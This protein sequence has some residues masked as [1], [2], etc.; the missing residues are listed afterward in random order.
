MSAFARLHPQL[1][2]ALVHELGW[3]TLRPVQ[4]ET[5]HAVLDGCNTIVLAPTAGGK[6]EAG[7]FPVLSRVLA[8]DI[9]PVAVLYLCPLRA[10]LNNLEGRVKAYARM[11]GLEAFKWHGDVGLSERHR[12]LDRPAHILM[13]TPESIEVLL[14]NRPRDAASLLAN[15]SAV[16]VDEVHAF[17]GDDRGAH[18]V[19]LLERVSRLGGR[20]VQRIGLS[21]TVG[22][23]DAI[24]AWLAGSS[25]RPYRRVDPPRPPA[26]RELSVD[27]VD[28]EAIVGRVARQV[29]GRKG[30]V[31]V[32]SRRAAEQVA[33]ALEE[34]G[35]T[36]FVHHGSVS[37]AD[38]ERA[39]AAFQDT[40]P[41]AIVCTSTLELGID[42]GDLDT[43]VQI[44]APRTVASV[45]QRMGRTGRRPG[46]A[47]QCHFVCREPEKMLQAAALVRLIEQGWV[48]DVAPDAACA[49][50]L[51]HQILALS[52][53]ESGVSRHRVMTW[54]AGAAPFRDLGAEDV[55][56]L[57]DTMVA[58]DILY[59]ADGLLSLGGEGERLYAGK[60]FLGL[61]AVF[62]TPPEFRVQ[63]GR[64]DVGT[65]DLA[66][67]RTIGEG[68]GG[69]TFRLAG[70]PWQI[71]HLDWVR[72]VCYVVPAPHGLAP[73]WA[74]SGGYLSFALCQAMKAVLA[75]DVDYPWL[76]TS[77]RA[78]LRALR[79]GYAP[80]VRGAGS[81][82]EVT[83][84]GVTWHTFAGGAINRLLQEALE[85]AG[86][87][88][89]RSGNLALSTAGKLD[90]A[91]IAG[92]VAAVKALGSCD[93]PSMAD[94]VAAAANA[95]R[96]TRFAPCLPEGLARALLVRRLVDV[97]G[98]GR[99]AGGVTLL[100]AGRG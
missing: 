97:A 81:V 92:A 63:H 40:G 3:R 78:E 70:R 51:A 72:H 49:H 8:E 86:D 62:D 58:R 38:R 9:A 60:N 18:L 20:D 50:V 36:A 73:R 12:F 90:G 35:T 46:A 56:E 45:L 10:L 66:F 59:E 4:E 19:S 13:T 24:G 64:H 37:R 43:V 32:E 55:R 5:I 69:G 74:G 76:T 65:L 87:I 96:L 26:W 77:A 15:L 98:A 2:H 99:V 17:A 6:T 44:D 42:V 39:E 30:L 95:G 83:D 21:A 68:D 34:G 22:N 57:V 71:Q 88:A 16:I 94:R 84:A 89:W 27:L 53:Q 23:P 93:W 54:L 91:A 61:Y 82:V 7:V 25:Q 75:D 100:D 29:T 80:V 31:F 28:E 85:A 11:V 48:E 14:V 1:Q 52:L 79:A 41:A 67:L 33:A 47:S